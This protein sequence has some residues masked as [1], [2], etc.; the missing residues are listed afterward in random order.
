MT[1]TS[2]AFMIAVSAAGLLALLPAC[3]KGRGDESAEKEN[4]GEGTKDF[5]RY[6]PGSAPLDF[7][8]VEA[9]AETAGA[10]SVSLPGRVSFD[11]D[12]TQRVASP[13]DGRAVSIL[14]K[15]GDDSS[16]SPCPARTLSPSLARIETARPSIG[17]ATRCV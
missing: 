2:R 1:M 14:A 10:T 13:I 7:I 6:N 8:K 16:M 15:L 4:S 17:E 5:V 3:S 12:H 9:V 11:E